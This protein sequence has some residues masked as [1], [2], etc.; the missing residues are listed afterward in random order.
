MDTSV[1]NIRAFQIMWAGQLCAAI[2][3]SLTGFVL[4]VWVFQTTGST[5]Q[6]AII[7]MA[8]TLPAIVVAPFAGAIVDRFDRRWLMVVGNAAGGVVIAVLAVLL[9]TDLIQIWHVYLTT[10]A[11]ATFAV[12]HLTAF[13]AV[14]PQLVPKEQLGRANG[15]LQITQAARIA[16]PLI[17][18]VLLATIGLRGVILIDL[19]A[20]GFAILVLL[21][22]RVS[23]Q[24]TYAPG[25]KDQGSFFGD[26]SYGLRYLGRRHRGLLVLVCVFAGF[27]FCYAVAGVLVQ[28]LILS[29]SNNSEVT[30]G[31][32]MF[33]GGAG[34]FVGSLVMSIWKGP[35]Q[36]VRAIL[37]ILPV[38]GVV[39]AL[40]GLTPSP[41]LIGVVAPLFLF[42]LPVLMTLS[43]VIVQTKVEAESMGRV[44][45]AVRMIG[46]SAMPVAYLLAP[47]LVDRV[48]EPAMTE[49]GALGSSVGVLIGT[50][51]GRGIALMFWVAGLLMVV[52]AVAGASSA[53]LRRLEIEIPDADQRAPAAAEEHADA[54][55]D[56][57]APAEAAA[58]ASDPDA[59]AAAA[60]ADDVESTADT[61]PATP[62]RK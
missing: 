27:N 12:L 8:N 58:V 34:F 61:E 31:V 13:F 49:T 36:R 44:I 23:R 1:G 30:L 47:L 14:T 17:A 53:R 59:R 24:L 54:A 18:G 60:T 38:A 55:S 39:L 16:A 21:L 29:V 40:H 2:G 15:M 62:T 33:C 51:Q 37:L 4:G 11:A 28:P 19:A 56:S 46:Q 45:A 48:V 57:A 7:F 52:L 6:F 5:T 43:M 9:W 32:L 22:V 20:T 3:S 35:Q 25:A 41:W 50:G 10:A 42:T 26:L